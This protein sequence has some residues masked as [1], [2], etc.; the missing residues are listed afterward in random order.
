V[1]NRSAII[2]PLTRGPAVQGDPA[3]QARRARI[4]HLS[5]ADRLTRIAQAAHSDG[6]A[7][8]SIFTCP[9]MAGRPS[10]LAGWHRARRP[11][12]TRLPTGAVLRH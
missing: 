9:R 4:S 8:V 10:V 7:L 6:S 1:S 3:T 2:S 11:H 12:G 5:A